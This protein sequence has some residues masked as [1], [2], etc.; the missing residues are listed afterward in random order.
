M[1]SS[2][3]LDEVIYLL[4]EKLS[5]LLKASQIMCHRKISVH[6]SFYDTFS[7]LWLR[8]YKHLFP[9]TNKDFLMSDEFTQQKR[10]EIKTR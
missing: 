6:F 5:H 10:I 9:L 1:C 8:F 7:E 3:H 2:S 4:R